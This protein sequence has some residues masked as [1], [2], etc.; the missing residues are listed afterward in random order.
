MVTKLESPIDAGPRTQQTAGLRIRSTSSIL[1]TIFWVA[2]FGFLL[3]WVY[4]HKIAPLY[5]YEGLEYRTPLVGNYLVAMAATVALALSLPRRIRRPSDF[6][7]WALFVFAVAPCLLV[8]QYNPVL[9]PEDAT[10]FGLICGACFALIR[11]IVQAGL[12]NLSKYREPSRNPRGK[13]FWPVLSILSAL[14][15]LTLARTAG[16]HLQYLSFSDVYSVRS[17]YITAVG[18]LPLAGY[19]VPLQA[20]I[21]NPLYM[22]VGVLA[23]RRLMLAAGVLGEF[24][25]YSSE[26]QKSTLFAIPGVLITAYAF[27]RR[28]ELRGYRILSTVTIAVG[29]CTIAD[30]L[31]GSSAFTALFTRRSIVVPGILPAAYRALFENLPKT[32]YTEFLPYVPN[33]YP[34]HP[35]SNLVGQLF[36]GDAGTSAN[37]SWLGHGFL[38]WGYGGMVIESLIIAALLLV[39]DAFAKG[40]P[41]GL[42]CSMF[43]MPAA[44]LSSASAFTVILSDGYAVAVILMWRMPRD[45]WR[46]GS[47]LNRST[48]EDFIRARPPISKRTIKSATVHVNPRC[49][50]PG[51]APSVRLA[52]VAAFRSAARVVD[53]FQWRG[54]PVQASCS[55]PIARSRK[56]AMAC[57]PLPVRTWQWSSP[58]ATSRTQRSLFSMHRWSRSRA[59]NCRQLACNAV[60]SEPV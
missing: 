45:V 17:D 60:R 56:V 14:N 39:T 47:N 10:I 15:Y 20:Q 55:I 24:V 18:G 36:V 23:R 9:S 50:W 26:G 8:V 29:M 5:A 31:L 19:L 44:A 12:P 38:S 27:R 57:G 41:L 4:V 32:H 49:P 30:I 25:I 58:K 16:L 28:R 11:A 42:T 1:T 35:P 22:A 48:A 2:L 34:D 33:P 37:V 43:L 54:F 3:Q 21:I 13:Y 59:L 46:E 52:L 7:M 6:I 40:L 53:V 51:S